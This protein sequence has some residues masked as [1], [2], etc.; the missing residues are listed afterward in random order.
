MV[1]KIKDQ[2]GGGMF[3]GS[4]ENP[5]DEGFRRVYEDEGGIQTSRNGKGRII[6]S[7]N[8]AIQVKPGESVTTRK[9]GRGKIVSVGDQPSF[10]IN[11]SFGGSTTYYNKNLPRDSILNAENVQVN[12]QEEMQRQQA[13]TPQE[14]YE[15]ILQARFDEG[16]KTG[17]F[18]LNE[19]QYNR[20]AQERGMVTTQPQEQPQSEAERGFF[21]K[22]AQIGIMPAVLAA[23]TISKALSLVGVD[24][25]TINTQDF[26]ETGVGKT[27]GL[28]TG[29]AAVTAG[30][31]AAYGL[32]S[33]YSAASATALTSARAAVGVSAAK[34]SIATSLASSNL[35]KSLFVGGVVVSL[36]NGRI[37]DIE[38]SITNQRE[39]LTMIGLATR[40]GIISIEEA[41][42]MF[43]DIES[44]MNKSAS[45]IHQTN[46]VSIKS[47]LG[48][49]RETETKIEKAKLQLFLERSKLISLASQPTRPQ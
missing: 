36:I 22:A 46:L 20:I 24:I 4:L 30:G 43:D 41:M 18:D 16:M 49:G 9:T 40:E 15:E 27:L 10:T 2:N 35:V 19:E 12:T 44:D 14:R 29:V 23:N 42:L 32:Y 3:S 48:K 39:T 33:G 13:M 25:G 38:G 17:S 45:A 1:K 6:S 7:G 8:E 26:S 34:T 47:Y 37:S 21:D 28:L 11:D 31:L 5:Q